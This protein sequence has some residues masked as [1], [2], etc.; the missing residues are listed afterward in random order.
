MLYTE[1]DVNDIVSDDE[2]N[3]THTPEAEVCLL[4][5]YS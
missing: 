2:Q 5:F 4:Y 3:L 1:N